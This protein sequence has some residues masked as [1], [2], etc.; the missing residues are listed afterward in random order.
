[1]KKYVF[2]GQPFTEQSN[3]SGLSDAMIRGKKTMGGVQLIKQEL[4][5]G[6]YRFVRYYYFEDT[7]DISFIQLNPSSP[8]NES[9]FGRVEKKSRT[10]H[11]QQDEGSAAMHLEFAAK[12]TDILVKVGQRIPAGTTL[13]RLEAMKME[14][15]IKAPYEL[16]I[17]AVKNSVGE[18]LPAG[19]F[20]FEFK[21]V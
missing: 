12:I 21:K 8:H 15:L 14:F 1:M 20:L 10:G 18:T 2:S 19:Q 6:G 5:N 9:L 16:I 13:A 3:K 17:Q 4:P 7:K 11:S